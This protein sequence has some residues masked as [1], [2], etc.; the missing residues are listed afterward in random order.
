MS[1]ADE[2]KKLA[3]L[4]EAGLITQEDYDMQKNKLLAG[5][6][7]APQPAMQSQPH[8]QMPCPPSHMGLAIVVTIF[9]CLPFGIASIVQGSNVQGL[10]ASGNYEAAMMKSESAKKWATWGIVSPLVIYA[11]YFVAIFAF[12]MS[13]MRF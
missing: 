5:G 4:V 7:S 6:G 8:M 10:W 12:G 13:G 2:L 3:E 1:V 9:C 11:L